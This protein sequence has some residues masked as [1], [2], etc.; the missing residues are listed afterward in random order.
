LAELES[1]LVRVRANEP[2]ALEQLIAKALPHMEGYLFPSSQG[3]GGRAV[4]RSDL[5]MDAAARAARSFPK[6]NGASAPSFL[7]WLKR[8]VVNLQIDA[9]RRQTRK[10]RTPQDAESLPVGLL[11][12]SEAE[13]RSHRPSERLDAIETWLMILSALLELPANQRESFWLH[14]IREL[15]QD[16]VAAKLGR[17]RGMVA[18]EVNRA[19]KALAKVLRCAEQTERGVPSVPAPEASSAD[20]GVSPGRPVRTGSHDFGGL[21][22]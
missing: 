2:R 18:G 7:K 11:R 16:E 12:Q 21:H 20:G 15:P 4:P 22:A 17:N 5:L 10:K 3:E 13:H 6:F 1:L 9:T 8:I 19:R 14:K